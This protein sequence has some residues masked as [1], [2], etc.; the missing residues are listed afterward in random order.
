[1]FALDA[2]Q[3]EKLNEW[4][5]KKDLEEYSGA[6]GGRFTY[7]FTPTSLGLVAKVIDNLKH[8]EIDLTDYACW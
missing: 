4:I 3:R 8:D 6:S 5:K 7:Q 1:M 2:E